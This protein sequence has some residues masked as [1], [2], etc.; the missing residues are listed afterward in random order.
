MSSDENTGRR[1]LVVDDSVAVRYTVVNIIQRMGYQVFEAEDGRKALA[2]VKLENPDLIILDIHMPEMGGLDVLHSLRADDRHKETPVLVLTASAD[3]KLVRRAAA[4]QI[5]GYLVKSSLSSSDIR[6]RISEIFS[7]S[8][9]PET[10]IPGRR[11][12]NSLNV[13]LADDDKQQQ[14]LLVGLLQKWGCLVES[15]ASGAELIAA[16][17]KSQGL[18]LILLN[19]SL[20]D[21]DGFAAAAAIRNAEGDKGSD[22]AAIVLLSSRAMEEVWRRAQEAGMDAY[23]GKPVDAGKLFQTLEGI[24]SVDLGSIESAP[25]AVVGGEVF[26]GEEL[27]ERVDG[28]VELLQRMTALYT[29]DYGELLSR[30]RQA[31]AAGDGK[32]FHDA[33]HTLKGMLGNLSAHGGYAIAQELEGMA[34]ME[35]QAKLEEAVSRLQYQA[36]SLSRS[37]TVFVTAL[38]KD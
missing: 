11:L 23:V 1:V 36:E 38:K 16:L 22:R 24:A 32:D 17:K 7:T 33:T 35:D 13:L 37:L 4:L 34:S 3:M 18:D 14:Q 15:V 30:I 10:A 31:I 2:L 25:A 27:L 8:D 29:R 20:H 19:E 9:A 28:D 6:K 21:Q 5:S 26:D 12:S